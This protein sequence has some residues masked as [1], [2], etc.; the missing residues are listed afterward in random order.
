MY[1]LLRGLRDRRYFR[2][3]RERLG[4]L[5]ASYRQ[6]ADGAVWLHAVSVGEAL[7]AVE[8]TRQLRAALPAAPLFVSAST[9][10]GKAAAE[11]KLR[12][13]AAGVFYAPLDYCSV[14]RRAL[15]RLRPR[16]VIV[17]ET[18]I[19]PNLYREAK[20]FGCALIVVNG[21]I[22]DRAAPRYQALGW[23]FRRVLAWPDAILAQSAAHAGRF[24]ALGAPEDRVQAAGNLKY[25]F[26]PR[27][28][29]VPEAVRELVERVAPRQVWIAASTMPP[30]AEG[31]P[32][33]DEAVLDAFREL[34][35][36]RP[37]LLL[38]LV[39]RRP[40][41]FDVAA[42]ALRRRGV[43][44]LRRSELEP[45]ATLPLPGALLLDSIGELSSLFGLADVVFMGGSL[46]RRGGHN[47]LEP[48][49]FERAIVTGPHM[50]NFA[51]IASRFAAGDALVQV[52]SAA[53]LAGAVAR[54][55]DDVEL[56]GKLGRRAGELAR[57]ERGATARA[58][59]AIVDGYW[60]AVPTPVSP[61][62]WF[63]W[64]LS[65][66]WL[67]GAWLD[68]KLA[69][70]TRLA[71]QVISV[72]GVTAGGAG[73]TP[74]TLWLAGMLRAQGRQPAVLT[75]GYR[76][77]APERVTILAP[78]EA[79]P[80]ERTG[81][82]AQVYLRAGVGPVGIGADRAVAG[83][84]IEERFHPDVFVLDDGFQHHRLAR[85]VDIVLIDA[86]NPFGGGQPIPLGRLREDLPALARAH[87]VVVTRVEPGMRID[88]I[89]AVVRRYN[90]RARLFTA[91]VKPTAW[92]PAPPPGAAA[93]FC[94]LG[95]P[96]GFWRT[97]ETAGVIPV[98]RQAFPDHHTYSPE[99]L[100]RLARRAQDAGA[101]ALA[102]T[103]KDLANLPP[104]W[105]DFIAPLSLH[106]LEVR[107]EVEGGESLI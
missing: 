65:R 100:R 35:R 106:V 72:G 36:E 83:R 58:V 107:L 87:I 81:D 54:A 105:E 43:P 32:D 28:A 34:A 92:R 78:G 20:R 39:P 31:D 74:F 12:G 66:L 56:R 17:M 22:S 29:R 99:E 5:P 59:A 64:P 91:R 68:R 8:L 50:E 98:L 19:W 63:L 13:V 25:D 52:E 62:R 94:G 24:L 80:V 61:W 103:E 82:E 15:R 38:I 16:A 90:P 53:E 18:E 27:Q 26:E 37:G 21:R 79:A 102:A 3:F 88:G 76:R 7:A 97:L 30:A 51:E 40:E 84:A 46:A 95:N 77:R 67:L 47:I 73:K 93:A 42:D 11:E 60:R 41:R 45:G 1:F 49:F 14:V 70:P 6:T 104:N 71:T 9:I 55:L 101:V 57:S 75:R 23:F 48:A 10:A 4:F 86:L 2:R 44:Y 96:E 85:D 69:R 33:E 89:E